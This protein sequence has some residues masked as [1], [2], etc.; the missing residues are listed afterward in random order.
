MCSHVHYFSDLGY[1]W[2]TH[3]VQEAILQTYFVCDN[4]AGTPIIPQE[5]H[6]P[7]HKQKA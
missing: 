5:F 1:M 4:S 2:H 3:T 6:I 7:V